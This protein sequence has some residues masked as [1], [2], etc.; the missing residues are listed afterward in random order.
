MTP[1]I[2]LRVKLTPIAPLSAPIPPEPATAAAVTTAVL[3]EVEVA[4][5]VTLA[6]LAAP[7]VC[8][9]AFSPF[10]RVTTW[11]TFT[12]SAP[13][14]DKAAPMAAKAKA[15]EAAVALALAV[16]VLVADSAIAPLVAR[17][18]GVFDA[19]SV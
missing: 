17:T 4:V 15:T 1:P 10:A 6:L 5:S 11:I 19:A 7:S 18:I 13:A 9:R 3:F 2:W 14:P 8:S 16:A 12:A